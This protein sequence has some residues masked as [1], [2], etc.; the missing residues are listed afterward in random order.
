MTSFHLSISKF[1]APLKNQKPTALSAVKTKELFES[2]TIFL[3]C[4]V[5]AAVALISFANCSLNVSKF[6]QEIIFDNEWRVQSQPNFSPILKFSMQSSFLRALTFHDKNRSKI[7]EFPGKFNYF[8]RNRHMV[9]FCTFDTNMTIDQS[10]FKNLQFFKR[11]HSGKKFW[12]Y[13]FENWARC[14]DVN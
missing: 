5:P 1:S 14:A 4:P 7:S 2:I 9:S 3:A 13:T 10:I 8:K 6:G 11:C 12:A